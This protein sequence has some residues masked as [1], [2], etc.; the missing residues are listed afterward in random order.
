MV[1]IELKGDDCELTL[2]VESSNSEDVII[3]CKDPADDD[4]SI[5]IAKGQA[6]K[7]VAF[8]E[9]LKKYHLPPKDFESVNTTSTK[10]PA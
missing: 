9:A 5:F 1:T 4:I 8:A 3:C 7:L 2:E 6:R 10:E